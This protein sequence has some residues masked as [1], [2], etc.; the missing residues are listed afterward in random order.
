MSQVTTG[1]R[2]VLS[3][4]SVY[5][6]FQTFM[7]AH[8]VR[9]TLAQEFI[10]LKPEQAILDIGCGP[11]DILD[12][13]PQAEYFG[14]DIS[15]RYIELA[16]KKYGTRGKF[17]A[18]FLMEEDLVELPK[19]DVVLGI[20]VLHH[21]DDATAAHVLALMCQ[22]LK[23]GG[24]VVTMDPCFSPGQ[25]KIAKFLVSQDRG[26]H[27]RTEDGYENLAHD[28]FAKVSTQVRH[29]AWIPYTRCFMECTSA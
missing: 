28:V 2:A 21:M 16:K 4:P 5:S 17:V 26:Q 7:G 23:P 22:G 18:K 6:A 13:L 15:E 29:Q 3:L 27:V 14:F 10:R 11:A 9:L 12:Y 19:F 25:G 1:V 8:A 20:G 24:R